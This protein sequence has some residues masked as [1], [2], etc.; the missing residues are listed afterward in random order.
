MKGRGLD[1]GIGFGGGNGLYI[2][3]LFFPF[4]FF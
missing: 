1:G 2:M 4:S 3:V